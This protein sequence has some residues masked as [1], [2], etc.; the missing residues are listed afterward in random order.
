MAKIWRKSSFK[1]SLKTLWSALFLHWVFVSDPAW[2]FQALDELRQALQCL[3]MQGWVVW[4][5]KWYP[6]M[7]KF[8][9][10]PCMNTIM[11]TRKAVG[12]SSLYVLNTAQVPHITWQDA[13]IC[14][15][16]AIG[17]CTDNAYG[18]ACGFCEESARIEGDVNANRHFISRCRDRKMAKMEW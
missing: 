16:Q 14:P 7:I 8:K 15:G 13:M 5:V 9:V 2:L 12:A 3:P 4:V 11:S 6:S 1:K 17:V 10:F 18:I